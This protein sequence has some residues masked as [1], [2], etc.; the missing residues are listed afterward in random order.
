MGKYRMP[1][2]L[3]KG[4]G[5]HH[6]PIGRHGLSTKKR[7]V[8]TDSGK[9]RPDATRSSS[10]GTQ[11]TSKVRKA[12]AEDKRKTD[13]DLRKRTGAA[14]TAPEKDRGRQFDPEVEIESARGTPPPNEWNP[15][16]PAN[17]RKAIKEKKARDRRKKGN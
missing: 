15:L 4:Y 17:L 2:S 9:A 10:A 13:S 6:L 7:S 8:N 3:D 11:S 5:D 16:S 1:E 12:K 14:L